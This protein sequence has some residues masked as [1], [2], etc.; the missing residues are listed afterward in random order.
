MMATNSGRMDPSSQNNLKDESS[1][2]VAVYGF[3]IVD[4][5]ACID[6]NPG[7]GIWI[8][9]SS[10]N[11]KHTHTA[12]LAR[13]DWKA[14]FECVY[15]DKGALTG[16]EILDLSDDLKK[17]LNWEPAEKEGDLE[18]GRQQEASGVVDKQN[19]KQN[20]KQGKRSEF[21]LMLETPKDG[22]A[23]KDDNNN[24]LLRFELVS[25]PLGING[26]RREDLALWWAKKE[27]SGRPITV[28]S[29]AE[30]RRFKTEGK[31]L[32]RETFRFL[33]PIVKVPAS[34]LESAEASRGR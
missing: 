18:S 15:S 2:A 3:F 11:S 33:G 14:Y 5:K 19:E 27:V 1:Q 20:E 25:Y 9:K 10:T 28:L 34:V 17:S 13:K 23:Q 24:H 16:L 6:D 26:A 31:I 32:Q 8:F 4:G 22:G 12:Y 30:L 29:E 7:Q 21:K